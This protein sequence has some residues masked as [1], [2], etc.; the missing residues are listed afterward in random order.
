MTEMIIKK[1]DEQKGLEILY[2]LLDARKVSESVLWT[3]S[4]RVAKL[5]DKTFYW[6]QLAQNIAS[7]YEEE[8]G[9][10]EDTLIKGLSKVSSEEF[11]WL[12][13]S[14]EMIKR[15]VY[16]DGNAHYVKFYGKYIAVYK[17][18]AHNPFSRYST[19]FSY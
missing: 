2:T 12:R 15:A 5:V 3:E 16:T 11:I 4:C 17:P 18:L 1:T 6:Y 19:V 8:V 13:G 7:R 14:R 9:F 10:H